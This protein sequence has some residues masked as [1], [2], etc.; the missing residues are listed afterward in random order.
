MPKVKKSILFICQSNS[1]RSQMAEAIVNSQLRDSYEAVSGGT[2][3]SKL[4]PYAVKVMKEIGIDISKKTAKSVETAYGTN[5]DY[6]VTLCD[7]AEEECPFFIK[8]KD[9]IHESFPDPAKFKGSEEKVLAEY[10]KTRD[11]LRRWIRAT[12]G[13][14]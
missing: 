9:Y 13:A 3:P 14:R 5:F 7:E 1:A 8:G 11:E 4:D 6:V 2:M 10:R 12:F